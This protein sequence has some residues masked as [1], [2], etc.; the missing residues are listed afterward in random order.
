VAKKKR[1][2]E[3]DLSG[4]MVVMY[5]S[6]MLLLL[7]FFILL[8]TM[9]KVEEK[10]L[11][12]AYTSL[13]STFGFTPGGLSPLQSRLPKSFSSM[14]P[15]ITRLDQDYLHLRGI[16]SRLP[17]KDQITLLRSSTKRTIAMESLML[18]EPDTLKITP[19]GQEYLAEVAKVLKGD[20]YPISLFGHTDDG[21]YMGPGG[22]NNWSLSAGRA[23]SVLRFLVSQ[24]LEPDR[25]AAFGFAGYRP[26]V[27][28]KTPADR[29]RN[30]RVELV[31]SAED[32]SR[33]RLPVSKRSPS[34]DFRGFTFDLF[35]IT[36]K[37]EKQKDGQAPN[38]GR[39]N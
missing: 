26:M 11:D 32:D 18:F 5:C 2:Q 21:P 17:Q 15:P 39:G 36:I 22:F 27:P 33:Y 13:M 28:N 10:R 24:G 7:A 16:V 6:L 29:R 34:V 4:G 38:Q 14:S 25:L 12:A 1:E 19:S 35:D 31:L 9:S 3:A 37:K 30:N 20:K 8:N 23:L